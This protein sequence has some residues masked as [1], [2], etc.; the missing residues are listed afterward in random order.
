MSATS[1]FTTYTGA[2]F[3]ARDQER[4]AEAFRALDARGCR[5]L[6]SNSATPLIRRLYRGYPMTTLLAARA[7]SS[8]ATG[9]G[10]IEELAIRNY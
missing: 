10:R 8:K 1:S 9:R 5:L 6:L 7:I 4:L 2:E 3:R